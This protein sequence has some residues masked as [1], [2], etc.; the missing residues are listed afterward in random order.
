[1]KSREQLLAEVNKEREENLNRGHHKF[2]GPGVFDFIWNYSNMMQFQLYDLLAMFQKKYSKDGEPINIYIPGIKNI[3][4][5][6]DPYD[7]QEFV[8]LESSKKT[9]KGFTVNF[10]QK[11]LLGQGFAVLDTNKKYK[12]LH[13]FMSP[14]FAKNYLKQSRSKIRE[15]SQE[16]LTHFHLYKNA[17]KLIDLEQKMLTFSM[18]VISRTMLNY[19]MDLDEADHINKHLN[20]ILNFAQ[21]NK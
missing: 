14:Y 21:E 9:K 13:K 4:I 10:V 1:M 17:G 5:L 2:R 6:S 18:L 11:Y 20:V 3:V 16:M 8:K 15:I 12:I 7:I 19:P